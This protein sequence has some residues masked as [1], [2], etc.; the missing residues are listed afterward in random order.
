MCFPKLASGYEVNWVAT[1]GLGVKSLV[2]CVHWADVEVGS[3]PPEVASCLGPVKKRV[4]PHWKRIID[5]FGSLC[6]GL[7]ASPLLVAIAIY[8][9]CVSRGPVLFKQ[10]RLGHGA[11]SITVYKF[12]TMHCAGADATKGHR[13]YIKSIEKSAVAAKP[14]YRDRLIP[15]GGAIRALSLDELPQL[16]N[17]WKGDM[18]LV[19]PR[20]DVLLLDDYQNDY[21]LRRFEVLPGITGLW[22]VSG[23]NR[24]SY[25]QMIDLDVQYVDRLSWKLDLWIMLKTL[26]LILRSD[27]S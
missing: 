23:K 11:Q 17:V 20:P 12:R 3:V 7:I 9:K 18:S 6:C 19:G 14:S 5:L 15:G 27:N 21:E 4:V 26:T 13:D 25:Q 2:S 24:L 8:I 16:W 1:I 22:Q 10:E